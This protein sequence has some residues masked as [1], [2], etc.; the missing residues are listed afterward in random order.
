MSLKTKLSG[1]FRSLGLLKQA[2]DVRFRMEKAKHRKK[3]EAFKA[4]NPDVVLPPDYLIYESFRMDYEIWYTRSIEDAERLTWLFRKYT[5]LE[6]KDILDWGCGPGRIIRH[7]PEIIGGNCRFYGTDY[8]PKSIE[9]CSQNLPGI[10]F[11]L[12]Q[13]APPLVYED[14]SMDV[15]Y[16]ISI[17]THLSEEMH[18]AWA[19][20][21]MRV[22]RPGG[23][24]LLTTQGDIFRVKLSS[25][26]LE[27][28]HQGKLV[29]RG[30][31]K[32]GHRTYSAFQPPIYFRELFGSMDVCEM[33][34]GETANG[35]PQQ[36]TW[37]FI[38]K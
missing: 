10:Q 13:L 37:V 26:E 36:D 7:M 18:T 24:L 16:G 3:N 8:N 21:L 2:D 19:Q 30:N 29:V 20:E 5:D 17:F 34:Q 31:V 28:Y 33:I 1:L 23:L 22:L 38:K 25:E 27:E 32:E 11:S 15:I 6:N 35:R 9:W 4:E 14:T 12:N